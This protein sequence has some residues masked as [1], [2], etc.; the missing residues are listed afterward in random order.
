MITLSRHLQGKILDVG[1]GGEGVIGRL[2]G[3]QVTAIDNCREELDEAPSGFAKVLMDA[4]DLTFSDGSFDH[5]TFFFS[6]MFMSTEDQ[7]R[8]IT[9][10]VRVLKRGGEMYIWDCGIASAYPE[11]FCVDVKIQL[12]AEQ[13]STTYGIGKLDAQDKTSI[14]T[15]CENAGLQSMEE[16]EDKDGFYLRFKK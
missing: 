4:T 1:G 10:A 12:P 14:Q 16:R 13:I 3:E 6:L 9:E 8:A 7:R 11:P 15:M 5:V 2:Y